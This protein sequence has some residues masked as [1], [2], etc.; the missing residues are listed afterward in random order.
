VTGVQ[1][2]ALPISGN[3]FFSNTTAI[4]LCGSA[5]QLVPPGD[6]SGQHLIACN[7]IDSDVGG[8]IGIRVGILPSGTNAAHVALR[9]NVANVTG[10][11]V[12]N[13]GISAP[14]TFFDD[15]I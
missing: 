3:Q 15:T 10:A 13:D 7:N 8:S 12:L 5:D 4:A 9:G 2:C 11:K 6:A 14:S 1:T